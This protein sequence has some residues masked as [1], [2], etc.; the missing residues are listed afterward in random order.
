MIFIAALVYHYFL[1]LQAIVYYSLPFFLSIWH[2]EY[3]FIFFSK[4]RMS[5]FYWFMH[6]LFI[7]WFVGL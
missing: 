1:L 4:R 5:S 3:I 2:S 6:C 7:W